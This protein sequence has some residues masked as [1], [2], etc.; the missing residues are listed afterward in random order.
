MEM[1]SKR[2]RIIIRSLVLSLT[3]FIGSQ[4]LIVMTVN[5]P[6]VRLATSRPPVILLD[7]AHRDTPNDCG[8][9]YLQWN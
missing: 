4:F 7:L 5:A 2:I 1:L 6:V 8:A 3:L 9:D